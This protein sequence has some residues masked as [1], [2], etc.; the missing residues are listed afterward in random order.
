MAL[1]SFLF[2][3]TEIDLSSKDLYLIRKIYIV[4]FGKGICEVP[5]QISGLKR[6]YIGVRC[7]RLQCICFRCIRQIGIFQTDPAW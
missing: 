4:N 7:I 2:E 3:I 5:I 6:R 1:G